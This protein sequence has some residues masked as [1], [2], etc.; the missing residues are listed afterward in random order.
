MHIERIHF[1]EV[2]DVAPGRGDFSFRS[3]GRTEYGVNLRR[4]TIP[5]AGGTYAVAFARAGDWTSVLGWRD[6]DSQEATLNHSTAGLLLA[7]LYDLY[8][9]GLFF[10]AGGFLFGGI[11]MA[12]AFAALFVAGLGYVTARDVRTLRR[13]RRALLAADADAGN[14]DKS[15]AQCPGAVR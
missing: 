15:A 5:R 8:L 4:G 6:L 11:G 3:G 12:L 13:A 14:P 7:R 9:Y 10:L 2:F 1:E